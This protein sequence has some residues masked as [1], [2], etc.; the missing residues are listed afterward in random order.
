MAG[1]IR[2]TKM[3]TGP[4]RFIRRLEYTNVFCADSGTLKSRPAGDDVEDENDAIGGHLSLVLLWAM[5]HWRGQTRY[6]AEAIRLNNRGVAQMGQQFTERAAARFADAMKRD[7]KMAQAAINEGIALM[8]LQKLDEA[9]RS[10]RR[11]CLSTRTMLRHGTTW[12][13]QSTRTMNW[14]ARCEVSERGRGSIP[15]MPTRITLK[16]SVMG[17]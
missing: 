4:K 8:T 15:R 14:T 12:V 10:L 7:P 16:A 13:L 9:R 3:G 17:S 2:G 6:D 5:L 11:R 1:L